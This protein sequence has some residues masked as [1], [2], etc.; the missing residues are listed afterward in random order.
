MKVGYSKVMGGIM[1]GLGVI[2]LVLAAILASMGG[3][4]IGPLVPGVITTFIGIMY[5]SR[6]YFLFDDERIVVKALIGPVQRQ[7]E[8]GDKEA[9]KREGNK[10]YVQT[11]HGRKKVPVSRWI[12]DKGD[13]EAFLRYLD[14]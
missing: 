8:Y 7:V 5:F 14:L 1:I 9:L 10:I 6:P 11:P 4:A 2:N 12:A 13:W 3:H